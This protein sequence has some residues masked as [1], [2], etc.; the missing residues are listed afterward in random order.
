MKKIR[1]YTRNMGQY[2][3]IFREDDDVIFASNII[4]NLLAEEIRLT[5]EKYMESM[6]K[7]Q[8]DNVTGKVTWLKE[9]NDWLCTE[10]EIK[11]SCLSEDRC[12]FNEC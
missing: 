4:D 1:F 2:Y 5:I 7:E 9:N 3:N 11:G 10:C 12:L 6:E 8:E